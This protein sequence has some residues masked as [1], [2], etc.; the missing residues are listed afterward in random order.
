M[1][2]RVSRT[3]RVESEY[4]EKMREIRTVDVNRNIR[5]HDIIR[6]VAKSGII[7]VK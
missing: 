5:M 2:G 7:C 1:G 4:S 6:V 3:A